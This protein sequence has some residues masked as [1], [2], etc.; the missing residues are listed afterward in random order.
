MRVTEIFPSDDGAVRTV[1]VQKKNGD[2]QTLTT[3]KLAIVDED[4]LDRYR[5]QQGLQTVAQNENVAAPQSDEEEIP[6]TA[7]RE[8]L[9]AS[10]PCDNGE[11]M[12]T[13][14]CDGLLTTP[15]NNEEN[16]STAGREGLRASLQ[17]DTSGDRASSAHTMPSASNARAPAKE[18]KL[19][20]RR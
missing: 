7:G 14:G 15:E 19:T 20:G 10:L 11:D 5:P 1:T 18:T 9:R 4:L 2:E 12:T 3:N 13:A 16:P 8:G 17:C 6:M